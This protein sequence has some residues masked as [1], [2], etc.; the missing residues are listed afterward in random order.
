MFVNSALLLLL[1]AALADAADPTCSRGL[2]DST[3]KVCCPSYCGSCGGN[4]CELRNGGYWECCVPGITGGKGSCNINDPPCNIAPTATATSDPLCKAGILN[5]DKKTCCAASCGTCGGEGCSIRPGGSAACCTSTIA[6]AAISCNSHQAPCTVEAQTASSVT[7]TTT[8]VGST[9]RPVS[10]AM[11]PGDPDTSIFNRMRTYNTKVDSMLMYQNVQY[12]NWNWPK[13]VLDSGLH[14][15]LVLEFRDSY[16]NLWDIAGGKYDGKLINFFKVVKADGRQITVRLLHE[17]NGNWYNWC[18]DAGGSNSI[19]AYKAAF[20]HVSSVI[21]SVG[22]HVKIQASFNSNN[23]N[24]KKTAYA[25]MYPGDEYLDAICVSAYQFCGVD[26]WHTTVPSLETIM[27]SWYNQ[28][29]AITHK[30]LCIAEMSSTN[31]CGGKVAWITEAWSLLAYKFPRITSLSWFFQNKWSAKEDL[32][33]N[34][35]AEI[36]AWR[37]GAAAFKQATGYGQGDES[38][39]ITSEMEAA[40]TAAQDQY[41]KELTKLGLEVSTTDDSKKQ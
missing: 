2:K 6:A 11:M 37:N 34:T 17:F 16:P 5:S 4:G 1:L 14:V 10:L 32:S 36:D 41:L 7:V 19:D 9:R 30:P 39:E 28:M 8:S 27:G 12:L 25:L 23:T 40:I 18:I 15:F 3:G 38:R 29:V 33:L 35:Q 22:A 20:R 21:R 31:T 26:I 13:T 24:D